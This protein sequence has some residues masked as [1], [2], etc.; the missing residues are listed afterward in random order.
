MGASFY[1]APAASVCVLHKYPADQL[2]L[3]TA[4]G[5]SDVDNL[6]NLVFKEYI[7]AL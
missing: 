6:S 3:E 2:G 7:G 4:E 1:N 5:S